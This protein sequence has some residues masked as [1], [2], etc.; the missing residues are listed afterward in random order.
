MLKKFLLFNAK[1]SSILSIYLKKS[2]FARLFPQIS[3]KTVL[4][5]Q[6][7]VQIE[8]LGV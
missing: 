3:R 4:F 5:A 7:N 8:Y 1:V 6:P 2:G